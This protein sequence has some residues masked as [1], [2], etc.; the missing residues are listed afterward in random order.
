MRPSVMMGMFSRPA[1]LP[2][3]SAFLAWALLRPTAVALTD[4][5]DRDDCRCWAAQGQCESNTDFMREN[6][7]ASCQWLDGCDRAAGGQCDLEKAAGAALARAHTRIG[8]LETQLQ[9]QQA[10]AEKETVSRLQKRHGEDADRLQKRIAELEAQQ[11]GDAAHEVD[12]HQRRIA[13]LE[14]QQLAAPPQGDD[15]QQC[16]VCGNN[17]SV[18]RVL[19]GTTA[20]IAALEG[21][22]ADVDSKHQEAVAAVAADSEQRAKIMLVRLQVFEQ[23]VEKLLAQPAVVVQPVQTAAVASPAREKEPVAQPPQSPAAKSSPREKEQPTEPVATVPDSHGS[24]AA[25]ATTKPQADS[26]ALGVGSVVG[27]LVNATYGLAEQGGALL[28]ASWQQAGHLS[29]KARDFYQ[30]QAQPTVESSWL[31]VADVFRNGLGAP[32]SLLQPSKMWPAWQRARARLKS[33]LA[34][35]RA[36]FAAQSTGGKA[37]MAALLFGGTFAGAWL[38][39]R[40]LK[41]LLLALRC[42]LRRCFCC[43][44]FRRS[45]RK[46][47]QGHPAKRTRFEESGLDAPQAPPPSHSHASRNHHHDAAAY[48]EASPPPPATCD[49]SAGDGHPAARLFRGHLRLLLAS[50]SCALG[51]RGV[52]GSWS[53]G[54]AAANSTSAASSG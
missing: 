21:R 11:S 14:A 10:A 26:G 12:R 36:Q 38:G 7:A 51:S 48:H 6:C 43:C 39:T 9:A 52:C 29:S 35:G 24:A 41:L 32:S 2:L 5:A 45:S 47:S 49:A 46:P 22:L 31:I 53:L 16:A 28:E 40:L 18:E 54:D 30:H 25:D 15:S 4:L 44:C 34:E 37:G 3:R 8:E 19:A 27:G 13:E 50:C 20:Q 17:A 1:R 33:W 23:Q 42:I